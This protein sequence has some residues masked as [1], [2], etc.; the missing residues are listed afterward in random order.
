LVEDAIEK[1]TLAT[2]ESTTPLKN[3]VIAKKKKSV[4]PNEDPP[5]SRKSVRLSVKVKK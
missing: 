4:V 1:E 2:K 5:F 3:H